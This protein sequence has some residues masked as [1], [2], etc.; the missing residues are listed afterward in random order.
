STRWA[1][2]ISVGRVAPTSSCPPFSDVHWPSISRNSDVSD[3]PGSTIRNLSADA[4]NKRA[5]TWR[6]PPRTIS[7]YIFHSPCL[8]FSDGYYRNTN[9]ALDMRRKSHQSS[10]G[11]PGRHGK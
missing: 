7:V 4:D 5:S 9:L 2:C 1:S 10:L 8:S 6:P 3:L 11:Y